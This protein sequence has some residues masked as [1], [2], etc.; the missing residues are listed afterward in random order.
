MTVPRQ[1]S[2]VLLV[3]VVEEMARRPEAEKLE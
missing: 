2:L 1:C 3:E